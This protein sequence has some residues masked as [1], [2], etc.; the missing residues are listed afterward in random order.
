[1]H[2]NQCDSLAGQQSLLFVPSPNL[3]ENWV[4]VLAEMAAKAGELG[5]IQNVYR[6]ISVKSTIKCSAVIKETLF[7]TP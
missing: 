7:S 4:R 6:S 5:F 2:S 1:M 3:P